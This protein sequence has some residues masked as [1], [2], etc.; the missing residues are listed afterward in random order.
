MILN[1]RVLLTVG[2]YEFAGTLELKTAPVSTA[3]LVRQFPLAGTLQHASWSG[4]AA[5]LPLS[6]APQLVTENPTTRPRPGQILLYTGNKSQAEILIPYGD[7]VFA[8]KAGALVGSSVITLDDSL[9]DLRALGSLLIAK[10]MQPLT[11]NSSILGS[12][13]EN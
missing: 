13:N 7:C 1:S 10:G 11:L 5:W 4:E 8:C 6:G 3:W 12:G 9:G 2:P